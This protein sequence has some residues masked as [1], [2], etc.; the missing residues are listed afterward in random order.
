MAPRPRASVRGAQLF[1]A[2]PG[3]DALGGGERGILNRMRFATN[4]SRRLGLMNLSTATL[5]ALLQRTPILRVAAVADELVA[6]SPVGAVLKSAA[7]LVASLGAIDSMAGA[8]VLATTLTPNPSG[9]LPAFNAT[10]G[11]TI[12]TF[13]R[14]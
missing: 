11:V 2:V 6:S 4:L 7:A 5:V 14:A 13:C 10:V 8:T 1:V 3:A 9:P 12:T